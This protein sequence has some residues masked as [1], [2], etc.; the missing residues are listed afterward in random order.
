VPLISIQD[1]Q[2]DK[3]MERNPRET[4]EDYLTISLTLASSI[5][6]RDARSKLGETAELVPTAPPAL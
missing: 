6:E 2:E 4:L 1:R 3:Q 5:S